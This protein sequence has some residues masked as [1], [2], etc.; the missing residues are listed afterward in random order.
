MFREVS[1]T[2]QMI[3]NAKKKAKDM[4]V[5]KG[6]VRKGTGN[7][8]GFLGEELVK[9]YFNIGDRNTYEWDL[10]LDSKKLECKAKERNVEPQS[11]YN[12]TIFSWNIKQKC[13]YYVFCSIFKNFKRGWICGYIQPKDFYKNAKFSKKGEI[14][15]DDKTFK[16]F[17]DC[18][19]MKYDKLMSIDT[20]IKHKGALDSLL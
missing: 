10:E 19:N 16:F 15:S 1:I 12:A 8:I 5:I 17:T 2:E 13:D 6:S 11:F 14:D 3:I 7:E 20:F 9:S 18:Y 4:G